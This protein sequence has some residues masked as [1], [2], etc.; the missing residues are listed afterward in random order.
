MKKYLSA[1]KGYF[2]RTY[3]I[4]FIAKVKM[5]IFWKKKI[6]QELS[7]RTINCSIATSE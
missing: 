3:V 4:S 7:Q 6:F 2:G 5:L 1:C